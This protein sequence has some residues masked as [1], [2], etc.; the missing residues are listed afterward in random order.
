VKSSH[1]ALH[2]RYFIL[3]P[4]MFYGSFPNSS[5]TASERQA[6]CDWFNSDSGSAN[7]ISSIN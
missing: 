4:T 3:R 7:T 5:S 2:F 6:A 1:L